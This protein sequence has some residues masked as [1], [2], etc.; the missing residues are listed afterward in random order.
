MAKAK[1]VVHG[2]FLAAM[3]VCGH[4]SNLLQNLK[5]LRFLRRKKNPLPPLFAKKCFAFYVH[6]STLVTNAVVINKIAMDK[7][8]V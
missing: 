8:C 4:V 1:E 2:I 3:R 6:S 5:H 7:F